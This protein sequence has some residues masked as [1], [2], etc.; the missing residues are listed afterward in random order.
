[1]IWSCHREIDRRFAKVEMQSRDMAH[2][3]HGNTVVCLHTLHTSATHRYRYRCRCRYW[4]PPP[5]AMD[6]STGRE[7]VR[8]STRGIR[9]R[10]AWRAARR[11]RGGV[12]AV[13][14][15]DDGSAATAATER[16]VGSEA[17]AASACSSTQRGQCVRVRHERRVRAVARTCSRRR[18][19]SGAASASTAAKR[20][21]PSA[22]SDAASASACGCGAAAAAERGERRSVG[23][24]CCRAAA[25]ELMV[26]SEVAR[27]A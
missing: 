26:A 5:H 15:S 6:K 10:R 3:T 12:A 4:S 20:P 17:S 16:E 18:G 22:A 24:C 14:A 27:V 1:M 2:H 8:R 25:V 13:A 7:R 23:G 21:L 11:R 9:R 19:A